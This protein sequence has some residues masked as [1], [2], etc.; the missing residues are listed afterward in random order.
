MRRLITSSKGQSRGHTARCALCGAGPE[1]AQPSGR[2][3][4]RRSVSSTQLQ[5]LPSCCH[6]KHRSTKTRCTDL[7]LVLQHRASRLANERPLSDSQSRTRKGP[8]HPTRHNQNVNAVSRFRQCG[9]P[10]GSSR[11]SVDTEDVRGTNHED[12]VCFADCRYLIS[13]PSVHTQS[14]KRIPKLA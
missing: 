5:A 8:A 7:R 12:R 14:I 10:A 6:T 3:A 1:V 11:L 4:R 13:R 2:A 9:G